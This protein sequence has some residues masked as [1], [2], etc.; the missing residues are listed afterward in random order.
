MSGMSINEI[1][2][3][4]LY[5]MQDLGA[6]KTNS[7]NQVVWV[8]RNNTVQLCT[9]S[10]VCPGASVASV[11]VLFTFCNFGVEDQET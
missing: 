9:R 7:G 6:P 10:A 4:L 3:F 8:K 2:I 5:P 11:E 1:K